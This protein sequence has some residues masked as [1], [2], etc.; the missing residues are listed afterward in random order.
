MKR[1]KKTEFI[2]PPEIAISEEFSFG[3][4]GVCLPSEDDLISHVKANTELFKMKDKMME[5]SPFYK[6]AIEKIDRDLGMEK[7]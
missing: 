3:G 4:Y 1:R 5:A 2:M 6:E 7:E